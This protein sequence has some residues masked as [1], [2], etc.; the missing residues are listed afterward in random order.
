MSWLFQ[1]LLG[2]RHMVLGCEAGDHAIYASALLPSTR[3]SMQTQK[4][5]FA[6]G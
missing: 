4:R 2:G 1:N 5:R 6:E 3:K